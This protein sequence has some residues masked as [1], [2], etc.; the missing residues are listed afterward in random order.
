MKIS[1]VSEVASLYK[2]AV[3]RIRYSR[4]GSLDPHRY[5]RTVRESL[6]LTQLLSTRASVIGTPLRVIAHPRSLASA[7]SKLDLRPVFTALLCSA[8]LRLRLVLP[9]CLLVSR[10]HVSLSQALPWAFASWDIPPVRASG[11]AACP[12]RGE[13]R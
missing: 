7:Q 3:Q 2:F 10:S 12:Q 1:L 9:L 13:S 11:L 5:F 8:C 6:D 4:Q